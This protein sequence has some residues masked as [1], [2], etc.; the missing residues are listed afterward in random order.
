MLQGM[1][2]CYI[3]MCTS[4]MSS[5]FLSE[6]IFVYDVKCSLRELNIVNGERGSASPWRMRTVGARVQSAP[7]PVCRRG[8]QRFTGWKAASLEG[9]QKQRF[10][11]WKAASLEGTQK[12]GLPAIATT[13]TPHASLCSQLPHTSPVKLIGVA[14]TSLPSHMPLASSVQV[15]AARGYLHFAGRVILGLQNNKIK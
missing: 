2:G 11:G 5:F 7:L 13:Y 8:K 10:T 6:S 3:V 4:C 9:T 12:P 1:T 14:L 15:T